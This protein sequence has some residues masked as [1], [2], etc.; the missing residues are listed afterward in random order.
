MSGNK[1][2]IFSIAAVI[3]A[4][5][6]TEQDAEKRLLPPRQAKEVR[7]DEIEAYADKNPAKAIHLIG[8]YEAVYGFNSDNPETTSEGRVKI[9]KL[10]QKSIN[11]LIKQQTDAVNERRWGAAASL[12]RSLAALDVNL[13]TDW[14]ADSILQSA[15]ESLK[16]GKNLEAFLSAVHVD[17]LRKLTPQDALPFLERAADI[18]ERGTARFFLTLIDQQNGGS[19]VPAEIRKYAE[20]RDSARDMIK[21]VA[22]VLVDRGIKVERGIG[23]ADRVLG[24]AF[25]IDGAGFL[26][27]NYHVIES[28]VSPSY[29]GYSRLY[30][31]MGD[32]TSPRIPAK[33]TGWDKTIDLAIIKAEIKPEY[34]FSVI[35]CVDLNVGD[36]V[37]AIG[38]PGGLEKTVTSGIVSALGRRFLQIGD[39]IQIDAAVNHGNSGGPVVD[40]SG[41]LA[42]IV[43]AGIEQFE[44]LN[45]AIPA[46]RLVLALPAML[47]G[48]K[49]ARP[50][51]GLSL[52]QTREGAEIIY[53]SPLT[54][55]AE[56][57]VPEGSF[58]ESINGE[59]ITAP[60]GT[61]IT[62]LQ[63]KLFSREPE[64]LISLATSD[65]KRRVI[66]MAER[67]ATPLAEAAKIDTRERI[68]MPLFGLILLPAGGSSW[69]PH[70]L[71]KRV[72]RGSVADEAGLSP[73]D[74]VRIYG[75]RL[76]EKDGY[77]LLDIDVK[78]RSSGYMETTMRLPAMLDSPDTL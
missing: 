19:N 37:L 76:E 68:A 53:V 5:C 16:A 31:R 67:P 27:T 17:E 58:I 40:N 12:S 26:V 35:D 13:K 75:L 44:G 63:D 21:G 18:C 15:K 42:G 49:A 34:V 66:Q 46:D 50:W 36:T 11:N 69:T 48:G 74:P 70:Y 61:L 2:I 1:R 47:K 52:V 8:I 41:R 6:V 30:I 29:K 7:I 28:E 73:Q 65:G 72:V 33:V 71:I 78:K 14:E 10:R 32:S 77:A 45:F 38:S 3:F 56:Q 20:G 60:Q 43:F 59:K 62:I 55:A 23:M 4:S 57:L 54:P 39:V 25:F 51:L 64:E 9:E 24:S 22:T